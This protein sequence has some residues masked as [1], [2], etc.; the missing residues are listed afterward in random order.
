MLSVNESYTCH[1]K[2]LEVVNEFNHF[3]NSIATNTDAK[4]VKTKLQFHE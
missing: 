2:K 4:I 1:L 3:F